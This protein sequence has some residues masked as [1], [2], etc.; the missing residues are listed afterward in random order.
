MQDP[1]YLYQRSK[2]VLRTHGVRRFVETGSRYVIANLLKSEKYYRTKFRWRQLRQ[3]RKYGP[4]PHALEMRW[5]SPDEIKT[6]SNTSP[7]LKW[8]KAG[9]VES[10]DWDQSNRLFQGYDLYTAIKNR[11]EEGVDWEET[12][13]YSRVTEQIKDGQ[14]KWGCETVTEFNSRCDDLE[15]LYESIK[16]N[17]YIPRHKLSS[18]KHD[19][20]KTDGFAAINNSCLYKYDEIAVDISRDGELLFVDGRNRLAICKLLDFDKIPVRV[21]R[22][23]KR[24]QDHRNAVINGIKNQNQ[25]PDLVDITDR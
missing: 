8:K 15:Q 5:V 9:L 2:H 6:I 21:V 7:S 19:V 22:R 17:G 25:H 20:P 13:F 14:T 11:F 1:K 4:V 23:H 24:W 3:S 16:E 18:H 10:G 12:S